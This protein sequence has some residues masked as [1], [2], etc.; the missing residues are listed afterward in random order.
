MTTVSYP[1]KVFKPN[2]SGGMMP[3][4]IY[5]ELDVYDVEINI[6]EGFKQVSDASY[7]TGAGYSVSLLDDAFQHNDD[8]SMTTVFRYYIPVIVKG[9]SSGTN[10]D[11]GRYD[12][13]G[14]EIIPYI[15]KN[16]VQTKDGD[17]CTIDNIEVQTSEE[18]N[19]PDAMY[20]SYI[21]VKIRFKKSVPLLHQVP[22][23]DTIAKYWPRF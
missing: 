16:S 19:A 1:P 4:T 6:D 9:Q 11:Y 20:H 7:T 18:L 15:Q 2:T 23:V 10:W 22:V 14:I 3:I 8:G 5:P 12:H 13:R 17:N 21:Q